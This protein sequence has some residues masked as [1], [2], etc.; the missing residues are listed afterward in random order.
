MSNSIKKIV[1][2][3]E[4]EYVFHFTRIDNLDSILNYG[5]L[6][7]TQLENRAISFQ[8]NDEYRIDRQVS[9]ICCSIGHPNYRMFYPYKK[10]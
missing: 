5:I 9:A 2:E 4:I 8:Y 7:R 1:R 6:G 10:E 3:R